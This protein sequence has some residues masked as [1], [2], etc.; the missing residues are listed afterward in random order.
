MGKMIKPGVGPIGGMVV[1]AVGVLA[2]A[3]PAA[4][5]A[6]APL[7]S[8]GLRGV[9]RALPPSKLLQVLSPS[10]AASRGIAAAPRFYLP[11]LTGSGPLG[12][13]LHDRT[14]RHGD[15]VATPDGLLVFEGR[16]VAAE[17][18]DADFAPVATSRTV[19]GARR[20]QLVQLQRTMRQTP[21]NVVMLAEAL[22]P[23]TLLILK[24]SDPEGGPTIV[25]LGAPTVASR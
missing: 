15:I 12:A 10:R 13:F 3:Q 8:V 11:P 18:R 22:E 17:H 23:R 5:H 21:S 19:V 24:R 2:V 9:S 4:A 14:L 16:R 6:S 1:L 25:K 20:A 7:A